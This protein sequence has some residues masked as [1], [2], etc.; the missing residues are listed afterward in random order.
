MT[1][2]T[3]LRVLRVYHSAVVTAWRQR[4]RELR[5]AGCAVTTVAPVRWVEGG[6]AVDLVT[7]PGED[8]VPARTFGHHPFLFLYD[9]R[10]L[11]RLLRRGGWDLLDIHEE[12]AALATFEVLVLARL[13]GVSAPVVLYS[14]QNIPKRYPRPFR[15][16]ERW[17]LRRAGAVHTCNGQ[18]AGVLHAK[19]FTGPVVDLGLGVDVERFAPGLGERGGSPDAEGFRV[20]YVGRLE[21]RK[22]IFVLLDA[23][24]TVDDATL[25]FVGGGPDAARLEAAIDAR[26]AHGRVEVRGFVDFDDL[27]D[28]YR[29]FDVL[30]VPSLDRRNWIEQFGRVVV[31]A[32]ASGVP[33]VAS[34]SGSL[35]EVLDGAG[36]VCPQGDAGLLA[37]T[38]RRLRDDPA[39]RADLAVRG[40][41]RARHFSWPSIAER[42]VALYGTV[43]S[44]R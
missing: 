27:P 30:V 3:S 10:P 38:L 5:S 33:V 19:G 21:E 1:G 16:F 9:P 32:M 22:G 37:G 6:G 15:W 29:G 42:Q 28:L 35:P 17:S 18:V 7:A 25:T 4:D 11:W 8:V 26:G 14:A 41:E 23:V 39:M 34:D 31:E 44:A 2:G 20:G 13:A 36:L 24:V 43:V 40:L 12:P